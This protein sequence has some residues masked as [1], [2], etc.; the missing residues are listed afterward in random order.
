MMRL[1]FKFEP[2]FFESLFRVLLLIA[3]QENLTAYFSL[4][5]FL[6]IENSIQKGLVWLLPPLNVI[7]ISD[8]YS[9]SSCYRVPFNQE[10]QNIPF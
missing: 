10:K 3:F 1:N 9:I 6:L 8:G 2:Q 4:F 7:F 5:Y